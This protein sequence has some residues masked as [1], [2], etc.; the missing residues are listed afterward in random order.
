MSSS[1]RTGEVRKKNV[2]VRRCG[3][4]AIPRQSGY[5]KLWP[6]T[7]SHELRIGESFCGREQQHCP[8]SGPLGNTYVEPYN[9][10]TNGQVGQFRIS[11]IGLKACSRIPLRSI[12]ATGTGFQ[13]DSSDQ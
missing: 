9:L 4:V 6:V 1:G 5:G 11:L 10:P 7:A 3:M 8:V 13:L 12:R 2:N